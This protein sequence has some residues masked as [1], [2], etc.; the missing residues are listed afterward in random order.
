MKTLVTILMVALISA[1]IS[2]NPSSKGDY[3][4][5]KDGKLVAAKVHLGFFKIHAKSTDGCVAEVNYNDVVT[6]QKNG[7]TFVKKPLYNGK[8]LSG[9]VFMKKISWR[10]GLGLYCYEDPSLGAKE[11][12][13]YFVFKDENTLWLEVDSKSAE[14]IK[15]FY[16]RM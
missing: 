2:A 11:N 14:N 6:F 12:K 16:N 7:E 15:N 8:E 3:V 13:R 5:T 4:L 9:E 10:N 1:T